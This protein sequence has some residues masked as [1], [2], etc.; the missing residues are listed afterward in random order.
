MVRSYLP[1]DTSREYSLDSALSFTAITSGVLPLVFCQYEMNSLSLPFID[2]SYRQ[3]NLIVSPACA[4]FSSS[5]EAS[6]GSRLPN[7]HQVKSKEAERGKER[8]ETRQASEK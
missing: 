6:G 5:E 4:S 8:E 7:V 1:S 2:G 3:V